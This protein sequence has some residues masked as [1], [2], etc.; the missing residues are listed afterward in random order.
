MSGSPL[1]KRNLPRVH[2]VKITPEIPEESLSSYRR[3]YMGIS[4]DNPVFR[5]KSLEGLL[6]WATERFEHCLVVTGDYLRRH[7]EYILNGSDDVTAAAAALAAGDAFIESAREVFATAPAGKVEVVRWQDC[8][9]FK[10]YN[11]SRGQLDRLFADNPAFR[12]ALRQ[13]AKAFVKRQL[14]NGRELA[15]R[16]DEAVAISCRYLLEEIAVFS[17]LSENGWPVELYPGAELHVLV[18]A[19]KGT[20]G[21]LPEGLKT[22][23]NVQLQCG[24]IESQ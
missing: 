14:R 2:V 1:P 8:L 19:A 6:R 3:C 17:A 15:T 10:E 7:N 11:T 5:G 22:R 21:Q 23:V 18:E 12:E 16:E 24:G 9:A 4:L 13:D 20:F